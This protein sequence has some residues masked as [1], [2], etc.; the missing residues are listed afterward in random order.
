MGPREDLWTFFT[1]KTELYSTGAAADHRGSHHP[2]S[3]AKETAE[4]TETKAG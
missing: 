2:P 3:V 4:A 1:H